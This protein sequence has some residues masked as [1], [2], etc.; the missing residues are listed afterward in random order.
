MIS[1]NL[2][3]RI[4]L[5]VS[6]LFLFGS[7]FSQ[8]RAI[9]SAE[10]AL[11]GGSPDDLIIAHEEIEKARVHPKTANFPRMWLVRARVYALV[12][13]KRGNPMM[14]K[15]KNQAGLESAKSIINFYESD[16]KKSSSDEEDAVY[17]LGNCFAAT[18]NEAQTYND[19][20]IDAEGDA[21]AL[22]HD[23]MLNYFEYL[24]K[25]YERLDTA[26]I[27]NLKGQKI[28]RSYFVERIAYYALNN[29]DI[30]KR[31]STLDYLITK[32]EPVPFV[33][34]NYSRILLEK[35]DTIGAK[36]VIKKALVKSNYNNDIFNVLVNYYLAIDKQDQLMKEV[37]NQIQE[38]PNS[39][40]YWIRGYLNERAGNYEAST[41]DYKK[42][43]ELDEYSYDAN[44]NLGVALM[45]YETKSILE[46]ISNASDAAAK[47]QLESKKIETFKT[48]KSYLEYASENSKYSKE[49][50]INISN[51]I[52]TCCLELNDDACAAEQRD[53][54]RSL[55]G[56]DF[57]IGDK[58]TYR[59]VGDAT[60]MQISYQNARNTNSTIYDQN[61]DW[62]KE[63]ECIDK[64]D[65]LSL[66]VTIK[67]DG[68]ATMYII[69]NGMPVEEK[70][71]TGNGARGYIRF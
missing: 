8:K 12:F 11:E 69:I 27:N 21:K 48:A 31:M 52:R 68:E 24:V 43:R 33:V 70:T 22:L 62:E 41:A 49:E 64:T 53:K 7:A 39:K 59:V 18:F 10:Y 61:G 29:S 46:A 44:W 28:E 4:S 23:T 17:I 40:N 25:M 56:F 60:K 16:Q 67:G 50:L 54:V 1:S 71:I 32:E 26:M 45:K 36:D 38:V 63:F 14:A 19:K 5:L 2:K 9:N 35:G 13:D 66:S 42:S 65:M 34:E 3:L 30:T 55:N 51:A 20:V 58:F 37:D 6:A 57:G 47:A 15:I